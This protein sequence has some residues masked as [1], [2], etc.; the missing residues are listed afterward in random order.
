MAIAVHIQGTSGLW[1][2]RPSKQIFERFDVD[3]IGV[4]FF[5]ELGGEKEEIEKHGIGDEFGDLEEGL[6][7]NLR[8]DT[9]RIT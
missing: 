9:L 3:R 8:S 1:P 4:V 7:L 6:V 2:W 5:K